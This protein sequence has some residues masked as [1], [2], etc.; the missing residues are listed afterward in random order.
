MVAEIIFAKSSSFDDSEISSR[1]ACLF[2]LLAACLPSTGVEQLDSNEEIDDVNTEEDTELESN[3]EVSYEESSEDDRDDPD[4]YE[5]PDERDDRDE[6]D[7]M[8][9]RDL[10]PEIESSSLS[11]IG[12]PSSFFVDSESGVVVIS[13]VSR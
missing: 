8:L 4:E 5:D 12:S 7:D 2:A 6:P 3:D 11:C 1:D 10:S 13:G 9:P